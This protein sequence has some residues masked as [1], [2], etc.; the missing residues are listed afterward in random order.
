MSISDWR[1]VS[2]SAVDGRDI[3]QRRDDRRRARQ[4][5]VALDGAHLV[6]P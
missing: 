5:D 2:P 6:G 4:L 3:G 1:S